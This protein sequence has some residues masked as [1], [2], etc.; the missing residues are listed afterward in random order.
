MRS[1]LMASTSTFANLLTG[2]RAAAKA[3]PEETDEEKAKRE[4]EEEEAKRE[5][6]EEATAKREEEEAA[7][8]AAAEEDDDEKKKKEKKEARAREL[9]LA[10]RGD[11]IFSCAAA[12]VRPDVAAFVTFRTSLPAV[13][14]IALLKVVAAG[15]TA[16]AAQAAAPA[17]PAAA[18]AAPATPPRDLR[19]RMQEQPQYEVGPE[20]E[21]AATG[22]K[23]L[24]AQIIAAG[25]KRRGEKAA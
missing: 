1:S 6:E 2:R 9:A 5:E 17:P 24:A 12:G 14:A 19:N 23:G 21:P 8:A 18:P 7:A 13:T 16:P 25:Q 20:T 3:K 10:Q 4:E 22:A 11:A 15:E